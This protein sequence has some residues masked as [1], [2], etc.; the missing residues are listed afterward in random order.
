MMRTK[1]TDEHL[2]ELYEAAKEFKLAE[3]WNWLYDTDLVCVENPADKTIGYCS[4]MGRGGEH[5][6]L[7]VYLGDDG[8]IK[9]NKIVSGGDDL[10][11]YL[12]FNMQNCLMCSF[13]DR[14]QLDSSDRMQ[15][16]QLGFSFRGR[17][18]W[19]GFRRYEP[20]YFNDHVDDEECVFL[21][22]AIR[23]T[24]IAVNEIRTGIAPVDF[25]KGKT[26]IRY[27]DEKSGEWRTR[28]FRIKI[29]VVMY[30]PVVIQDDL[31]IQKMKRSRK[32]NE[33][34]EVD[35]FYWPSPVKSKNGGRSFYPRAFILAGHNN[36]L[37]LDYKLFEDISDDAEV[38]IELILNAIVENG[39][40]N[41]ILV[42][43]DAMY[44]MLSDLCNK[45]GVRLRKVRKL[46]GIDN[47]VETTIGSM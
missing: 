30:K 33:S 7:G 31:M 46:R 25:E 8:I 40:P 23:Q 24:I 14:D 12:F 39:L 9:F 42:R 26:I 38:A 6:A 47:M 16:K 28:V 41:E 19:P 13:M 17:N 20:G 5:F 34:Y 21:T 44:A 36:G 18:A 2:I 15:I 43:N 3:P 45:L 27:L 37:V 32:I 10:P 35:I 11:M 1:P 29:P 22:Q 4:V